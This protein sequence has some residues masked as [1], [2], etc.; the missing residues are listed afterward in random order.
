[1]AIKRWTK[2]QLQTFSYDRKRNLLISAAAGSGKTTVMTQR[3]VRRLTS[4]AVEPDRI[5]VMTFTELAALEMAQK[6]ESAV[7]SLQDNATQPAAKLRVREL[8]RQL[9]SMQISTIHSFCK[10][11][12]TDYISELTDEEGE[13]LLEPGYQ[14]LKEE[15]K[16]LLLDEATQD[17]LNTLYRLDDTSFLGQAAQGGA[18]VQTS[19][20]AA[21]GGAIAYT[22]EQGAQAGA[23]VQTSE[24]AAHS[25]TLSRELPSLSAEIFPFVLAG[26]DR[27][28]FSWL[29][30]FRLL[31]AAI[32]PGYDDQALRENLIRMLDKLRS[33]AD[34]GAWTKRE[35][36]KNFQDSKCWQESAYAKE[37]FTQLRE[38][39]QPALIDLDYLQDLPYWQR[40][41]D[42]KEKAKTITALADSMLAIREILPKLA[43]ALKSGD[44]WEAIYLLGRELPPVT[45]LKGGSGEAGKEFNRLFNRNISRVLALITSNFRN[46]RGTALDK[47]DD[48]VYPWFSLSCKEA[49]ESIRSSFG[50][51]CRFFEIVLLIDKRYQQLKLRQNKV[52]FDDFEHYALQLLKKPQ[53]CEEYTQRFQEIYIDEYQDTSSIQE[54]VITSFSDNNIFMV[55]DVKQS[56]YRFRHANP[57]LIRT[58]QERFINYRETDKQ[59]PALEDSQDSLQNF[60][61]DFSQVFSPPG[62]CI[63]LNRNFRSVPGII[64]FIN[65]CFGSFLSKET[66]EIEYDSSQALTAAREPG[67]KQAVELLLAMCSEDAKETKTHSDEFD[68]TEQ[69]A[70]GEQGFNVEPKGEEAA[71]LLAVSKIRELEE[72]NNYRLSDIAILAPNHKTLDIWR[73]VLTSQGINVAGIP[74]REFL[75]SP[76]LRQLEALVQVLDNSRQDYPLTA[77]LLSGILGERLSEEELLAIA[78]ETETNRLQ[79]IET[80]QPAVAGPTAIAAID[81]RPEA[82]GSVEKVSRN[83]ATAFLDGVLTEAIASDLDD[84]ESAQPEHYRDPYFIRL[85][86]FATSEAADNPRLRSKLKKLL[87][88]IDYWRLLSEDLT[89][90]SLLTRILADSDYADHLQHQRFASENLADL[91]SFLDWVKSLERDGLL[92]VGTLARY[93]H[94]LREKEAKPEEI[95]PAVSSREAVQVMTVHASKGLEFPVVFLGGLA[96]NY[97]RRDSYQFANISEERGISSYSIDPAGGGTYLNLPHQKQLEAEIMAEKAERWRLLYVAMTRAEDHLYLVDA[98]DKPYG[99]ISNNSVDVAVA[100]QAAKANGNRLTSATLSKMNDNRKLLFHLLFL[101]DPHSGSEFIEAEE[102]IFEFPYLKANVVPREKIMQQVYGETMQNRTLAEKTVR[103]ARPDKI[104]SQ[105]LW[106]QLGVDRSEFLTEIN[107]IC[108]ILSDDVSGGELAE[109]P[110]KIT[111]T[112]LKRTFSLLAEEQSET[113]G[114]SRDAVLFP[115]MA[116]Q[117]IQHESNTDTTFAKTLKTPAGLDSSPATSS[118]I[119]GGL[120][121]ASTKTKAE[122]T[123]NELAQSS[124]KKNM[125]SAQLGIALHTVFQFADFGRLFDSYESGQSPDKQDEEKHR[126][127]SEEKP[128][129]SYKQEYKSQLEDMVGKQILLPEEMAAVLPFAD[130]ALQFARSEIGRRLI[131]AESEGRKV[132]REQPF[133]LAV[134]ALTA[135]ASGLLKSEQFN[136]EV[137]QTGDN[138]TLLQGMIDL[139]FLDDRGLILI[140]FKSDY[141]PDDPYSAAELIHDRYHIQIKTYAEAVRRAT[142]KEVTDK[143]VWL[144]RPSMEI[145]F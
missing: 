122:K 123:T 75:D 39:L 49:E 85:Y 60:R 34:Y 129:R 106:Q 83:T 23:I 135:S 105:E 136:L 56:I 121:A 82:S 10:S 3:I 84:D 100:V 37:L 133:V 51:L 116:F 55:G 74:K 76:V 134:P 138:I 12:I 57:D 128:Y 113:E 96:S 43:T 89:V 110:G 5:V 119:P 127:D 38:C 98:L 88:K 72:R 27:N 107:G 90:Y 66:G 141:V 70:W 29:K 73:S 103:I 139:W 114:Q 8:V 144:I 124:L 97:H 78:V 46:S 48:D 81:A 111:V 143:K 120:D 22:S 2:E 40:I 87:D 91:E 109:A 25:G 115:D 64:D 125:P 65:S 142:G 21:Q 41:F 63:N 140:D 16:Q 9:P 132:F 92:S 71:A 94:N 131:R 45:V 137:P 31:S 93:I 62:Y 54:A 17:V 67:K 52:D 68:R 11:V 102:G 4:G 13:P 53:I 1:M 15:E 42:P 44:D 7:R 47:Y 79:A 58:K 101:S 19:E 95:E 30:D 69:K 77:V 112:E 145:S 18:I 33:M 6:I 26:E 108:K 86:A 118:L 36:E 28:L 117:L 104:E 80:A 130:N 14:V 59:D 61:E 126:T 20:Q 32:A 24:Q 35:L 50:P 99:K